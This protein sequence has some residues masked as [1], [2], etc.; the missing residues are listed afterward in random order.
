MNF[1]PIAY[2]LFSIWTSL[3]A[4][5]IL[6]GR[7]S[8]GKGI[9]DTVY[10]IFLI[11]VFLICTYI[12]FKKVLPEKILRFILIAIMVLLTLKLSIYRGME[13]PWNGSIFIQ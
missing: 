7:L 9:G 13:N 5:G 1:K 12:H 3:V 11:I 10:L 4:I 2:I 6:M 8:F